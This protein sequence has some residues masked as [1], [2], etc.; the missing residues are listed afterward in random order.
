MAQGFKTGGRQK[1]TPNKNGAALL[2]KLEDFFPGYDPLLA[3][4]E[5]AQNPF[6]DLSTRADC[7]KTLAGYIYPKMRTVGPDV[8]AEQAPIVI[9]IINPHSSSD[10]L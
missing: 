5:I 9:E 1:G 4:I 7:H 3:L 8:V 2:A 10:S 6:T